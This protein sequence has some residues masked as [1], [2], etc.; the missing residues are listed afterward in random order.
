MAMT[1][2]ERQLA[3][4]EANI[5]NLLVAQKN[6]LRDMILSRKYDEAKIILHFLE[7][8]WKAMGY[9]YKYKELMQ[10]IKDEQR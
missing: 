10:L 9:H 8:C 7:G 4:M 2:C 5:D 1:K 3:E 6:K